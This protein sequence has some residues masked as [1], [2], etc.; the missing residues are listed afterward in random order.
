MNVPGHVHF[1]VGRNMFMSVRAL[2]IKCTS[3]YMYVHTFV[4][5]QVYVCVYIHG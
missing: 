3:A 5:I 4:R 2:H 1:Y